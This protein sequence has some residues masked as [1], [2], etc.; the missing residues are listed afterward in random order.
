MIRDKLTPWRIAVARR[1]FVMWATLPTIWAE[2][3][4]TNF[5]SY[6]RTDCTG[7]CRQGRDCRGCAK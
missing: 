6:F 4:W 3:F 5:L 7:N 2:A 1:T